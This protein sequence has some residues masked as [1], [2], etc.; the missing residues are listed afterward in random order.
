MWSKKENAVQGRKTKFFFL[1]S[2]SS[3]HVLGVVV[4]SLQEAPGIPGFYALPSY[5][6]P[7]RA[8][9]Q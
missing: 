9:D 3:L 1:I 7:G 6:I 8:R 5:L 4:A 2:F